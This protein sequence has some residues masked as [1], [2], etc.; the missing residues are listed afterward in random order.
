VLSIKASSGNGVVIIEEEEDG[1][2]SGLVGVGVSATARPL[3]RRF[4][5][6]G[7]CLVF[8]L[9]CTSPRCPNRWTDAARAVLVVDL[10]PF[11]EEANSTIRDVLEGLDCCRR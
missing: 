8:S 10:S 6:D 4:M 7:V 2:S 3:R 11:E 5:G 1:S 9:I